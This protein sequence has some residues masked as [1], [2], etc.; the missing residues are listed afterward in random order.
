MS[1]CRG[2]ADR[3]TPLTLFAREQINGNDEERDEQG[4]L[5]EEH[6]EE[7]EERE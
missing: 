6:E 1:S 4:K 5:A 7:S 3:A 2:Y